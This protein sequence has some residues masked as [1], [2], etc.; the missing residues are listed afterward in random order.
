M[1]QVSL[2]VEKGSITG[3]IGPNGA[4]K[5]TLFTVL[6]SFTKPDTGS[7]LLDNQPIHQKPPH[8]LTHYGLVRTFQVARVLSRLSVLE[9]VMLAAQAHPGERFWQVWLR[10]QRVHREEQRR[11]THAMEILDSVGLAHMAHDY[12]GSLS[13]G[14]RKLLEL[15]RTLMVRPK[16]ILF[17][18]PAAGTYRLTARVATPSWQQHLQ[19]SANGATPV[20]M[21][22]PHTVG[23]W[24]EADGVDVELVAGKNVLRL[25]HKSDGYAKGFAIKDFRLTPGR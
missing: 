15:A 3:L 24:G 25:Q 19:V 9:N 2:S 1:D 10:P 8:Q 6:A 13:G 7:V 18:A 16:I 12:A 17:D 21:V 5:T 4:G 20:D 23:L 11:K 22:L 14:Q